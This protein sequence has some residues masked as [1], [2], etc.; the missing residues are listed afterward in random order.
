MH[1]GC[2]CIP[3]THPRPPLSMHG[4]F[5]G[6]VVTAVFHPSMRVADGVSKALHHYDSALCL[7]VWAAET[8]MH[9]LLGACWRLPGANGSLVLVTTASSFWQRSLTVLASRP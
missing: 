8:R 6:C 9:V 2:S 7:V 1:A 4:C 5:S 3:G